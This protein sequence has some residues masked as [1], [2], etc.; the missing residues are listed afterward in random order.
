MLRALR[1]GHE[2]ASRQPTKS[3]AVIELAL[4]SVEGTDLRPEPTM[5][6]R[7]KI[8]AAMVVLLFVARDLPY[9]SHPTFRQQVCYRLRIMDLL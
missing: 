6:L 9:F 3:Q 5:H 2:R 4:P 1:F 7:A 8:P